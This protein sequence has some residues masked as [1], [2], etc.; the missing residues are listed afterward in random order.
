[1]TRLQEILA[2]KH[3]EVAQNRR[4][5]SERELAQRAR[6]TDPPRGF[7]R[8]L[9]AADGM[10]L[11][12]EVKR[13]SPSQGM[14]REQFDPESIARAYARA[15]A[16]CVSVLT[17][18]RFFQGAAENLRLARDASGLPALRKDFVVDSYQIA[19]SRALGADAVLL[20]AAA[21]DRA[22]LEEY[23]ACAR[24]WGMDV[25]LEVHT[26]DE[27]EIALALGADLVGVNNRDLATFE[28]SLGVS[29]ALIPQLA[30][31]AFVL[32]E[33]AIQNLADVERVRRAGARGV[34]I[35]TA[36]CAAPD[37]EGKVREVM[38]W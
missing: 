4:A 6:D 38:G 30:P 13:A 1:M 27:V 19:E 9:Q 31:S 8:A 5:A 11:V 32:S 28:T 2:A 33:S 24:E 3:E 36:F 21:L 18:R 20:I 10:A 29:D 12:A 34:L 16:H 23:Q 17:D 35:G 25:L 15:G 7:L 26:E 14:I 37:V 22:Q